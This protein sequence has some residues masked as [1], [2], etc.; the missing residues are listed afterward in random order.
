APDGKPITGPLPQWAARAIHYSLVGFFLGMVVLLNSKLMLVVAI[1]IFAGA[2]LRRR[3]YRQNKLTFLTAGSALLLGIGVLALTDNPI[4]ARYRD[5]AGGLAV[6]RQPEF[7][8]GIYFNPIQLRL[9]EW[10]FATGILHENHAWVFGVSP[11]DSQDLLDQQYVKTHMYIGN[12]A[13]GP[14]RH[15]RGFIGYNFHNQYLETLVRSGLLGLAGLLAIFVLL[16]AAARRQGTREAWMAVL[17]VAIFFIPE[18]PLTM[19]HGVFLFC[20]FPL[21]ALAAPKKA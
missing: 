12:P 7:N 2:F 1:V 3:T 19:Q 13:D 4:S 8:P 18:A 9:L 5:M 15:I 6:I 20:F 14:H 17:I 11:G 16:F 21:L 10:R